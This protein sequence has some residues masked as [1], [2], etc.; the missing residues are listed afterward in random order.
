MASPSTIRKQRQRRR[1]A[2]NLV[3][4]PVEVS[5][6]EI[7]AL[8]ALGRLLETES[9]DRAEIAVAIKAALGDYFEHMLSRV[10]IQRG[11]ESV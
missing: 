4:V 11:P 9:E 8:I 5:H 2:L 10:D 3:V 6:E 1:E 7:A